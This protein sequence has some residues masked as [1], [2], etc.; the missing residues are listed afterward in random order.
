MYTKPTKSQGGSLGPLTGKVMSFVCILIDLACQ[1]TCKHL[2]PIS[3]NTCQYQLA[4]V[5]TNWHMPIPTAYTG[6]YQP[7]NM[8]IP[9]GTCQPTPPITYQHLSTSTYQ[10]TNTLTFCKS[11]KFSLKLKYI[12]LY[13]CVVFI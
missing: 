5:N 4:H 6:Q 8:P 9:T 10:H 3:D 7:T 13:A 12:L 1:P 2:P 11:I